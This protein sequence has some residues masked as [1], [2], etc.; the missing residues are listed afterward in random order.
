MNRLATTIFLFSF[1]FY[2]QRT[3]ADPVLG[4]VGQLV[5]VFE[6]ETDAA[7]RVLL[8]RKDPE[9]ETSELLKALMQRGQHLYDEGDYPHAIAVQQTAVLLAKDLHDPI[10]QANAA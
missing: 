3:A 9:R 4:D 6:N 2:H 8:L 1:L 5:S 10:S 7:K